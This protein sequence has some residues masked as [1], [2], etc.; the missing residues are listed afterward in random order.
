MNKG[1]RLNLKGIIQKRQANCARIAE[2]ADACEK[3][4]RERTQA[5]DDEYHRLVSENNMLMMRE[6]ALA[7]P[8]QMAVIDRDRQLREAVLGG[9]TGEIRLQ[10]EVDIQTSAALDDTGIIPIQEEEMLKPLRAGLIYDKVGIKVLTGLTAGKLR[11][12]KHGK[13]T[14]QFADEGERLVDNKI[15]FGKLTTKPVRLGIAVPVTKEELESSHGIVENVVREEMPAAC[16]D[17]INEVMFATS[18]TFKDKEGKDKN[19]AIYGP[20]VKAYQEAIEFAGEIPTRKELLKM[21]AR[22]LAT[23]ITVSAPCWVMTENMKCELED[24]KVDQGSGRFVCEND[25][26]LGYPV[27]CTPFIGEGNIAFG[28]WSYQ[29]AGFFGGMSLIVDPYTLARNNATDFVLNTHFGTETLY[30]EAFVMGKAKVE[31][32]KPSAGGEQQESN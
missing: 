7:S 19:R 4:K 9:K 20:L 25:T 16:I 2:I 17:A 11:W 14:A 15:D 27:F 6:Q 26:I 29:P 24:T 21:K 31:E 8:A 12:P 18:A 5:E 23:G 32:E 10:R 13:A 30:E 22:V 3:E 28:D 1:N